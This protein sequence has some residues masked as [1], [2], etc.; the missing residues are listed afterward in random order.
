MIRVRLSAN[1]DGKS[2]RAECFTCGWRKISGQDE[3][4]LLQP[5]HPFFEAIYGYSPGKDTEERKKRR[6]REKEKKLEA[7]DNKYRYMRSKGILKPWEE[8]TIRKIVLDG[9]EING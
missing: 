9:G 1:R 5:D 2:L 3:L 4:D 6:D 7:L 8:A